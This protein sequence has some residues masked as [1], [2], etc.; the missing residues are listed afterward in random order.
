MPVF[1]HVERFPSQKSR[2][3]EVET[4]GFAEPGKG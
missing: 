3:S 1:C 4:V 2:D